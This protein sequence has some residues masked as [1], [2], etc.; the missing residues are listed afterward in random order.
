MNIVKIK[1]SLLKKPER[2]VRLHT[3][4]QIDEFVRSVKMFGQIRPVVVDEDNMILAGN[5]L[6]EALK[7][8]GI[9]EAD[10]YKIA[11]LT[12]NQKKKLMIAD[13]RIFNLGVDDL[14]G[15][16]SFLEELGDDYDVPGFDE[17][18]LQSMAAEADEITEKISAYGTLD[19]DEIEEI[20]ETERKR[21]EI[22]P[23]SNN[24]APSEPSA[25]PGAVEEQSPDDEKPY[26]ICPKCGE[27]IWL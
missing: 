19:D 16:N 3:E 5:G 14:E 4:K 11:D 8:A 21:E 22:L 1:V 2:N 20:K 26:V 10:C 17:E 15:L 6:V 18:I 12:E 23:I 13:N 25:P 7:K 24:Q 27:K 9:A